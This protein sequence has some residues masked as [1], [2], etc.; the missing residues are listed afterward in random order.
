MKLLNLTTIIALF[1]S[2]AV[3]GQGYDNTAQ[4]QQ[5]EA[6]REGQNTQGDRMQQGQERQQR[7]SYGQGEYDSR[8]D[9]G[10]RRDKQAREKNWKEENKREYQHKDY[11]ERYKDKNTEGSERT[12][13]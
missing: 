7:P 13:Y 6:P 5:R 12:D 4:P 2:G 11:D 10:V 8:Y 3:M 1:F 9:E